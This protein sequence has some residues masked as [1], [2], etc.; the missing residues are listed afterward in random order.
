MPTLYQITV[1]VFLRALGNMS[2]H[3]EKARDYT[4]ENGIAHDEI[5]G[6][7]LY[8]DMHP[9]T[10]QV[11]R[12]SDT[13][14]FVVSRVGGL[15]APSMADNEK[16]FDD[17]QARIAAT[18]D[19]LKTVPADA[20]DGKEGNPV[21]MKFGPRSIEFPTAND[22]VLIFALP[23]FWFHATTTYD[24]LRH[25]GVPVGKLDFIGVA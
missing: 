16:T 8:A 1:P 2:K 12:A 18:R 24:I 6:A 17:L 10:A 3:L 22:Y 25:K 15:Q 5:T 9:L 19:F 21:S 13:S 14:K 20:F 7:R 4:D 23:N 11:Q